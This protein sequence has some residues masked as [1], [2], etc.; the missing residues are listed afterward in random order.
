MVQRW[1]GGRFTD[2]ERQLSVLELIQFGTLD[3]RLAAL[4]WLIMEQRASVLVAAGPSYAGKTTMLNVLLDFLPPDVHEVRLKGRFE[5]F[6]FIKHAVPEKTYIVAEE[7]SNHFMY[8][9]VWGQVAQIAFHL[10]NEGFSLGGTIHARNAKEVAYILSEYLDIPAATMAK[11]GAILTLRVGQPARPPFEPVRQLDTVSLVSA[12]GKDQLYIETIAS[13]E[14]GSNNI[15]LA[16]DRVLSSALARKFGLTTLRLSD[17]L[18][19]RQQTLTGLLESG[20]I[21]RDQVR[22]GIL[23]FYEARRGSR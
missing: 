12:H 16:S 13:R 14:M 4:L 8:E 5:D 15:V 23:A 6:A 22:D 20:K 1:W 19:E 17:E 7:F 2:E 21:S 18:N 10:L 11:L 9:Y 3:T